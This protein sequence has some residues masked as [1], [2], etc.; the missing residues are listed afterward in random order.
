MVLDLVAAVDLY[1]GGVRSPV[2]S[3]FGITAEGPG[4]FAKGPAEGTRD[5][6]EGPNEGGAPTGRGS[7]GG[8][9]GLKGLL[10]HG[11]DRF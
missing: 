2:R 3:R 9:L 8:R 7:Y 6:F 1:V 11:G 5:A 4:V 10:F